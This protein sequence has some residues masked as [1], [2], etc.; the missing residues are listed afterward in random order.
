MAEAK[1]PR[2]DT[3]DIGYRYKD[4]NDDG[5]GDAD[6]QAHDVA[7]FKNSWIDVS[8]ER[9]IYIDDHSD[10]FFIGDSATNPPYRHQRATLYE[11]KDNLVE[12][13]IA[14]KGGPYTGK[15]TLARALAKCLRCSLASHDISPSAHTTPNCTS[16][17]VHPSTIGL[18][19]T[20]MTCPMGY[21]GK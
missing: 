3:L 18:P 21:S 7:V 8:N 11:D 20:S 14:M 15:T 2:D 1:N 17:P 4:D 13:V 19:T 5:G 16:P 10:Y 6:I 12:M 9:N